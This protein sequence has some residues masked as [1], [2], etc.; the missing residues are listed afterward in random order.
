[1]IKPDMI[2]WGVM[3]AG[4]LLV[5]FTALTTIKMM[6]KERVSISMTCFCAIIMLLTTV[7]TTILSYL[8]G[9]LITAGLAFVLYREYFKQEDQV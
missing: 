6:Q 5:E 4:S 8:Y 9:G 2:Q 1:M 3:L 7:Y